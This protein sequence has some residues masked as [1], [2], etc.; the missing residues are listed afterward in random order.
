VFF[1]FY[2]PEYIKYPFAEFHFRMFYD[3][4]RLLG[5]AI[6]E[7]AW[8][9]FRE[10]AKTSIAKALITYLVATK[11]REYLNVDSFDKSN[12]EMILFDVANSL[13]TNRGLVRDYGQLFTKTKMQNEMTLQRISKFTTRNGILVEAHSTSESVRGRLY[14]DKRPDFYL[15]DDFETNKTKDSKAYIEQ[16]Q[17]HIDELVTSMASE[18][19]VIYLGNYITEFGVVKRLLE[20]SKQDPRLIAHNVPVIEDGVA[21]WPAKYALTDEEAS[22]TGKVSLED[23]KRQVGSVVFSAEMLN[24]PIDRET[25]VFK[26]EWFPVCSISKPMQSA[27]YGSMT[28]KTALATSSSPAPSTAPKSPRCFGLAAL[29][30]LL[31]RSD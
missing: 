30:S 29:H 28:L 5:G 14:R 20:R 3:V 15:L 23:K 13:M 26:T 12:A 17:K 8:I 10:S 16:V 18:G 21:T 19:M 4:K 27:K 25:A 11:Q 24:Q 31:C 6:R 9:M 7:L 1:A 2:F 22:R